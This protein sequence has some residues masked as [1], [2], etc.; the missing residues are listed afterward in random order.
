MRTAP[1]ALSS[2]AHPSERDSLP[3]KENYKNHPVIMEHG[4]MRVS[5]IGATPRAASHL[6]DILRKRGHSSSRPNLGPE[7]LT[8]IDNSDVIVLDVSSPGSSGLESLRSV[9]R[10]SDVPIIILA[11][12]GEGHSA[13]HWLDEGADDYMTKPAPVRELLARVEALGRR[14]I[15]LGHHSRRVV[16]TMDILVDFQARTVQVGD[17]LIELTSKECGVLSVLV[18]H[19]G[20]TVGRQKLIKEVWREGFASRSRALDVHLSNLRSKL[21][22]PDLLQTVR[23]FGYRWGDVPAQSI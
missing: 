5:L 1:P 4:P 19:A 23:G 2:A 20:T 10:I 13:A 21:D 17:R 9:R 12:Y 16:K 3:N 15:A 11:H 18:R 7:M 8:D 14:S 6:I 22:R